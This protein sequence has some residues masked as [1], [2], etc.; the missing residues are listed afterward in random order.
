M[1]R[2]DT[3]ALP[4]PPQPRPANHCTGQTRTKNG[5]GFRLPRFDSVRKPDYMRSMMVLMPMP[6]PMHWVARP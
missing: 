1:V 2:E 5:G 4:G 6:A 3:R